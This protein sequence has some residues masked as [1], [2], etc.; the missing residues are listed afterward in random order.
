MT[1]RAGSV[2]PVDWRVWRQKL[3]LT[4]FSNAQPIEGSRSSSRLRTGCPSPKLKAHLSRGTFQT[5]RP[6][7]K[8]VA[9]KASDFNKEQQLSTNDRQQV[10]YQ[11]VR[12]NKF[13][14]ASTRV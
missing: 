5:R 8:T 6:V 1:S 7:G 3:D 11:S 2:K 9:V 13:Q 10:Q 14:Q 4:L 12:N